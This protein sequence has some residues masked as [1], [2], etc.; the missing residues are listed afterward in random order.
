ME[1]RSS[2]FFLRSTSPLF[3]SVRVTEELLCAVSD[4]NCHLLSVELILLAMSLGRSRGRGR[5]RG[6]GRGSGRGKGSPADSLGPGDSPSDLPGWFDSAFTRLDLLGS[7][8]QHPEWAP[9]QAQTRPYVPSGQIN[10]PSLAEV[11]LDE[12]VEADPSMISIRP[13]SEFVAGGCNDSV[14]WKPDGL[15]KLAGFPEYLATLDPDYVEQIKSDNREGIDC[16]RYL[17]PQF[18]ELVRP[19]CRAQ[20]DALRRRD[21]LEHRNSSKMTQRPCQR[22]REP[23]QTC[24]CFVCFAAGNIMGLL[25]SGAVKCLGLYEDVQKRGELPAVVSPLTIEVKKPRL[26]LNCWE[27]NDYTVD[28]DCNLETLEVTRAYV[29]GGPTLGSVVDEN[30]GYLNNRVSEASSD[31]FGFVFAGYIFEYC[32]LCFGWRPGASLHQERGLLLTGF[33]RYIGGRCSQ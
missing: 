23:T 14:L 9:M 18:V 30:A 19:A 11:L 17:E 28:T 33:F 31:F 12:T 4:F 22:V 32:S 15:R 3:F 21:L 29:M 10:G 7:A 8:Y 1:S 13:A 5:G 6:V 20:L 16:V 24:P 27:V 2:L 25:E 26:C